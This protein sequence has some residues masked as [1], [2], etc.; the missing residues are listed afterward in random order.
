MQQRWSGDREL[1]HPQAVAFSERLLRA[2]A[3]M[4]IPLHVRTIFDCTVEV[5]HSQWLESLD[6]MD[7]WLIGHLGRQVGQLS[8][9]RVHW[10][11]DTIG[12]GM[13]PAGPSWWEIDADDV[14]EY[15]DTTG[16]HR[17]VWVKRSDT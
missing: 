4:Q 8:G 7:W 15:V 13:L 1:A 17:A 14:D 16:C 3:N 6:V 2:A 10:G 12:Y 11:G 9:I 5:V